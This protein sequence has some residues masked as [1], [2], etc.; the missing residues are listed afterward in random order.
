MD[1]LAQNYCLVPARRWLAIFA[2]ACIALCFSGSQLFAARTS[3]GYEENNSVLLREILDS[4]SDL[5]H[6]TSNHEAEIRMF[7]DKFR[8][9]EDIFDKARKQENDNVQIVK[10]SLKSQVNESANILGEYKQ[11][12]KDLEKTVEIQ[13]QNIENLQA[14]L[15]ALMQAAEKNL[16][17]ETGGKTYRVKAG[18]SLERIARQNNTTIKKLKE[19]NNLT[20]DQ[21]I[22]GQKLALPDN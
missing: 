8:N 3:Y 17:G 18:D 21:I 13:N 7:E 9:L 2:S 10:E 20:G 5:R 14:A 12:I 22:V 6:Q 11:R 4:I 15:M 19:L 1:L 16:L